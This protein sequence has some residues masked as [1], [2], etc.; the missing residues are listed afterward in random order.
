MLVVTIR[1]FSLLVCVVTFFVN[2][3]S[4]GMQFYKVSLRED[5]NHDV[6]LP[7]D[8]TD[9][10][11]EYYGIHA[12]AGWRQL[13]ISF[14]VG[15]KFENTFRLS[16]KKQMDGILR[17]M[18]T[19]EIAVGKK[20]FEFQGVH[21]AVEGDTF[22]DLYTSLQDAINGNYLDDDWAKTEKPET[23][24]A[25]T[26]WEKAVGDPTAIRTADIRF[27]NDFYV[28][29]DS[30]TLQYDEE[31][32]REVVDME[33]LALHELGH[34]LGLA[35]V[36]DDIDMYSTMNPSMLIGSGLTSRGVSKGDIRRIQ[37]IYG[38]HGDA[39]D[40]DKVIEKLRDRL[41]DEHSEQDLAGI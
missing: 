28:F 2:F 7:A 12:T 19:W 24:L 11:S 40:I 25:T 6:G 41:S 22:S 36:D 34:L 26:I 4:C 13:P 31:K 15:A 21:D 18:E 14:Q 9:P 23:V 39:C 30:L 16:S 38:C 29:G 27:N 17:A 1:Y 5:T 35:H 8:A 20:L 33:S 3:I 10:D 32:G 37:K